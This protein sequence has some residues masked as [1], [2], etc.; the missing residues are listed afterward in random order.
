MTISDWRENLPKNDYAQRPSKDL[1]ARNREIADAYRDDPDATLEKV[2]QKYDLTRER[3]RQIVKE[4]YPNY[5]K[6][7]AAERNFDEALEVARVAT[8]Y[9]EM[10]AAMGVPKSTIQSWMS[11]KGWKPLREMIK[12]N[13]MLAELRTTHYFCKRCETEKPKDQFHKGRKTLC[14]ACAT[15]ISVAHMKARNNPVLV[16]EKICP[17]CTR[18]KPA[19]EFNR[20]RQSTDGLQTY[21]KKCL[22]RLTRGEN[23]KDIRESFGM[24]YER[25]RFNEYRWHGSA[26]ERLGA[27]DEEHGGTDA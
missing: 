24:K 3:V 10:A 9:K 14:A 11:R 25:V 2:S 22:H 1:E 13:K 16:S 19:S 8:S 23:V 21:C 5:K 12:R 4:V 15:K 6:P 20:A 17:A 18:L 7:P 26:K 27:G